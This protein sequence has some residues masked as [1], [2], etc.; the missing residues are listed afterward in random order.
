MVYRI[1][2]RLLKKDN[3]PQTFSQIN[4]KYHKFDQIDHKCRRSD[5]CYANGPKIKISVNPNDAQLRKRIS[6]GLCGTFNL[7]TFA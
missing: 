5:Y 4:H 2:Q 7:G 6:L 3:F 1:G